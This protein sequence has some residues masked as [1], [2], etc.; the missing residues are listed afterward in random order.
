MSNDVLDFTA[1]K[2]DLM[3][4]RDTTVDFTVQYTDADSVPIDLTGF[5]AKMEVRP[6]FGDNTP[7][8]SLLSSG[9]TGSRLI[10]NDVAG[11]IRVIVDEDDTGSVPVAD[12][13]YDLVLYKNDDVRRLIAGT[14]ILQDAVTATA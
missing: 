3:I 7:V 10:V 9:I 14:F 2:V 11:E 6:R 8:L 12:Y 5:A 4:E 13:V 1:K